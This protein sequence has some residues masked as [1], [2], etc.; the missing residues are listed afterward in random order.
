MV[1]TAPTDTDP[2]I[3]AM[4][5]AVTGSIAA[6]ASTN[7]TDITAKAKPKVKVKKELTAA[8]REVQN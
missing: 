6:T 2:S 3:K 5:V 7:I 4:D 8:E 1:N